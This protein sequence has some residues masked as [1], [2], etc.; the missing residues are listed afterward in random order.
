MKVT[1]QFPTDSVFIFEPDFEQTFFD[2]LAIE[3]VTLALG[4]TVLIPTFAASDLAGKLFLV[5][6]RKFLAGIVLEI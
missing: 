5:W 6:Q 1:T 4:E 3:N 2:D